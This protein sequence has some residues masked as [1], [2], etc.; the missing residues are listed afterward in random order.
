M[1]N[2]F[3][4]EPEK[5]F[6]LAQAELAKLARHLQELRNRA[7][8]ILNQPGGVVTV[9]YGQA[10]PTVEP[11]TL[12]LNLFSLQPG[13]LAQRAGLLDDVLEQVREAKQRYEEV[14]GALSELRAKV[15]LRVQIEV[16]E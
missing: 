11:I 3:L 12:V 2:P 6:V 8:R 16:P 4:S 10:L 5:Q 15:K 1:T 14:G 13:E 7:E 9:T